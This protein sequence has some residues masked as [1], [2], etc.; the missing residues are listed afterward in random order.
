MMILI[1]ARQLNATLSNPSTHA[2][3]I[4]LNDEKA[5]QA[6]PRTLWSKYENCWSWSVV[7]THKCRLKQGQNTGLIN[8]K[9][10][11]TKAP[12][13]TTVGFSGKIQYNTKKAGY[14]RTYTDDQK[15]S[16][17]NQRQQR[18]ISRQKVRN[19]VSSIQCKSAI[20]IECAYEGP[21]ERYPAWDQA[22]FEPK[23]DE[24]LP[25]IGEIVSDTCRIRTGIV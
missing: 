6:F 9:N 22:E 3:N 11:E 12:T 21:L 4:R 2:L 10:S 1:I 18:S 15:S 24:N 19:L 14:M 13:I 23:R 8:G 7:R 17:D 16:L 5:T 25:T 20:T